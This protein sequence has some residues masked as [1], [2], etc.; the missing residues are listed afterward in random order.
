[1]GDKK[2]N[3]DTVFR[4]ALVRHQKRPDEMVWE[5]ISDQLDKEKKPVYLLWNRWA[6]GILLLVGIAGV[7]YIMDTFKESQPQ[8]AAIQ[9]PLPEKP[10]SQSDQLAQLPHPSEKPEAQPNNQKE[11][12][13]EKETKGKQ[14]TIPNRQAHQQSPVVSSPAENKAREISDAVAI[15]ATREPK[16][17]E[18]LQI[19]L[20]T[21]E[22][23]LPP[24]TRTEQ[25]AENYTVRVVSRGYAL[26]PEK[27]KLV[28]ELETKI[29]VFFTR[30]DEGF[31]ELQ[32]AKNT[33][34]A[35]L[36]TKKDRK[37]TK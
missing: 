25:P 28:E 19:N 33:I 7:F 2:K 32:D 18:Q 22:S 17:I 9:E 15:S 26:Q 3:V 35:S 29:G 11:V 6:A 20:T 10:A 4:N 31:G 30:V 21:E 5:R 23:I 16:I 34:F 12:A 8:T 1:M 27:D 24:E 13:L 37:N 14:E 36:T